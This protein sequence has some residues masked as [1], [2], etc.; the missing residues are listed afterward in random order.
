MRRILTVAVDLLR[1]ALARKWFLVLGVGI[2]GMLVTLA[3]ALRFD[4]VDG[5]LA[6]TRLFGKFVGNR[7]MPADVA[8]RP[9]FVAAS[10]LAFFG[11]TGFGIVAC[12]DFGPSLLEPGRIE[13]L[14]ALPVRRF[15]LLLGT[16]LGVLVLAAAFTAY[17]TSG[18]V[19]VL[20]VKTGVWTLRPLL[21]GLLAAV[22]FSAIYAAMLAVAVFV[23]SAALSASM[24]GLVLSCG[25][26]ASHRDTLA[27]LLSPGPW[28]S[29]FVHAF[30]IF[31]RISTL[32]ELAGAYVSHRVVD[33]AEVLR[34]AGGTLLFALAVLA[35]AAWYFEGK[36]Y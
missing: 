30:A 1:E 29:G 21:A 14:L 16:F 24:G 13:H 9:V 15:E 25:I 22:S 12:S 35:V 32:A 31:P 8:L 36:D 23:R 27:R 20:G 3:L 18:L 33:G 6:A 26:I 5:A 10:Y 17:G 7:M 34:L 28:R 2:T 11:G 4:V 19:V